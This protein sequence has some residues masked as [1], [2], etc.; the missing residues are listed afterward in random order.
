MTSTY[1]TVA[2][3]YVNAAPHIGYGYE[4]VLAD[5]CAR[6]R[7]A[8]PGNEVRFLGGTDDYSLK[9]VLAAEAV[10][11]PVGDFVT[12]NAERFAELSG[13]LSLSF[14]DF[15]R[16][17]TDPRHVPAVQRLWEAVAARGD[18]Y[19]RTYQG[20][21]CVGCEQFYALS[22][23]EDGRCREHGTP[24]EVTEE[25]N[26]F[27]RLSAYQRYLDELISSGALAVTPEPFR[28]EALAFVRSGLQD[29]SVSRSAERARGWGIPVPGDPG[30][31]IYV[32]FDALA[33]Y[34]SALGYGAPG[35]PAYE[36]WWGGSDH[37]VH[38]V[39]KG[40]LRF[41]AVFWPAFLASAGEPAPTRVHVHPYLSQEGAK[42]SKSSGHALGPNEVVER[43][44]I[45]ALRWWFARDVHPSV[46]TDFSED[47]LVAVA[48]EDL[49]GGV[50][51]LVNRV[52]TLVHR[53]RD[54]IVP[55]LD[56]PPV[57]ASAGLASRVFDA[58]AD[59]DPR[60]GTLLVAEAVRAVNKDLEATTPWALAKDASRADE[61]DALLVRYMRSV[62]EVVGA[63]AP[64]VPG[65]A[66]RLRA[67][68]V[69]HGQRLA[70]SAAGFGRLELPSHVG[71]KP[72]P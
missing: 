13:S 15:I 3:P 31:V 4:L 63:I 56:A 58:L 49:A 71:P 57:A 42:L 32:W 45:D 7:R 14:D 54:G 43:Y 6:A 2:I 1:L 37:R 17:S 16:T 11:V 46:D 66:E 20:Y 23:L 24:A 28:N 64:I 72:T 50:G 35:S 44:G 36:K 33:N 40:I 60:L 18:L 47:R 26:W 65:L 62:A 5:V 21:Y 61:F 52:V 19:R 38:V 67:Q 51:N 70:E 48:N 9:N 10:G 25:E 34:I 8:R 27:F 22:E 59:L 30:Q 55:A 68:I 12:A 29:L 41:H 39:G 53:Y 69:P